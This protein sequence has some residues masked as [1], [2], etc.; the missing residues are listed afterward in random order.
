MAYHPRGFL[1]YRQPYD[2]IAYCPGYSAGRCAILPAWSHTI[3]HLSSRRYTERLCSCGE[4][5]RHGPNWG[6]YPDRA[7]L[8][9]DPPGPQ[10][11]LADDS[12]SNVGGGARGIEHCP[13]GDSLEG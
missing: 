2:L 11:F 1:A 8:H 7:D 3:C 6:S 12:G 13:T 5:T 9:S 4:C 10:S